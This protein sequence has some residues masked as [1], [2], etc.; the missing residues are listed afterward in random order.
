MHYYSLFHAIMLY[1]FIEKIGLLCNSRS[2]GTT[3]LKVNNIGRRSVEQH[4]FWSNRINFIPQVD[5]RYQ[6]NVPRYY[7]VYN[8][9]LFSN[10]ILSCFVSDQHM[11]WNMGKSVSLSPNERR[12]I[13]QKLGHGHIAELLKQDI[14]F[15]ML[16]Y[17]NLFRPRDV[18]G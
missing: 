18:P 12:V 1:S 13:T 6:F 3:V 17:F 4:S 16:K 14:R 10:V 8:Y 7:A 11:T 5:I 2:I 15:F 9:F